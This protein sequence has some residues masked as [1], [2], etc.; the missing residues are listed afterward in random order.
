MSAVLAID[1]G[2]TGTTALVVAA[3]GRVLGR[4]YREMTQYFPHPGEVEH[5]P[6]EILRRAINRANVREPR[7]P[8]EHLS[9]GSGHPAPGE[10][11]VMKNGATSR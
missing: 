1:S 9:S 2:T 8:R 5:E 4:G 6:E 11:S 10:G 7:S 3:D